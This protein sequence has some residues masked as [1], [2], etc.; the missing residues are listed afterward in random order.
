MRCKKD[1]NM[2]ILIVSDTHGRLG[3]FIDVYEH[4]KPVD[5]V[6]HLGDITG[7]KEAIEELLGP[8]IAFAVVAG[9]CDFLT[10]EIPACRDFGIGKHRVHLEHGY[11]PPV[12]IESIKQR[13]EKSGADILMFGHTHIPRI[14]RVGDLWVINPGSISR[15]RQ[16]DGKHTY[17][18]MNV[19]KEGEVDFELH[20]AEEIPFDQN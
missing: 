15:P 7:D 9:N 10:R 3:D 6:F 1:I 20:C 5:M 2:K 11:W 14:D 13:A 18:I 12:S 8:Q 4:E 19:D 16:E 17:I